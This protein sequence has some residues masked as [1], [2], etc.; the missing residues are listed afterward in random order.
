MHHTYI[1]ITNSMRVRIM[2]KQP[3]YNHADG[4]NEIVMMQ[5]VERGNNKPMMAA[6]RH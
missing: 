5:A 2:V 6:S 1:T 3:D 4:L